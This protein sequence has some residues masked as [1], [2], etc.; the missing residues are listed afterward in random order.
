MKGTKTHEH[1]IHDKIRNNSNTRFICGGVNLDFIKRL[2]D[3]EREISRLKEEKATT[4]RFGLTKLSNST[5]A[6]QE[7]VGLSLSAMQNNASIP[8][9]LR[10]EIENDRKREFLEI[11]PS[12]FSASVDLVDQTYAEKIG[13]VVT[14]QINAR[15]SAN[16]SHPTVFLELPKQYWPSKILRFGAESDNIFRGC[17][18]HNNGKIIVDGTVVSGKWIGIRETYFTD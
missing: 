13:K 9:T 2:S 6:T 4:D 11:T 1:I 10:N 14:L 17:Y 5:D 7:N 8:G 16:L 12:M 3:V 15:V 18:L